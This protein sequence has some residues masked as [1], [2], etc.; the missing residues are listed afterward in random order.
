VINHYSHSQEI[1]H[2]I[3]LGSEEISRL[4][5]IQMFERARHYSWICARRFQYTPYFF[6]LVLFSCKRQGLP[7]D[8]FF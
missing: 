2:V 1:S 5:V 7:N 4:Y 8:C 3:E 6:K